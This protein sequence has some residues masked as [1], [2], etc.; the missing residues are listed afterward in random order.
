VAKK[1]IGRNSKKILYQR[2]IMK[3]KLI[4]YKKFTLNQLSDYSDRG[5]DIRLDGDSQ[6]VIMSREG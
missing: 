4:P 6:K 1:D 3:F 2:L 5:Y